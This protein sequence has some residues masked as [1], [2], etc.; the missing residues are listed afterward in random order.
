MS[1]KVQSLK[2]FETKE[3]KKYIYLDL[4]EAGKAENVKLPNGAIRNLS[5]Y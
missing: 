3:M 4:R 1:A 5:L 2:V